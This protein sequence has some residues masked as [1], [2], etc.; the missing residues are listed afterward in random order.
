MQ[1]FGDYYYYYNNFL[2][3]SFIGDNSIAFRVGGWYASDN[4]N[5]CCYC[6]LTKTT[7]TINSDSIFDNKKAVN[8]TFYIYVK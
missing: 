2:P 5:G 6:R 8:G 7:I 3:T 1:S 4:Y